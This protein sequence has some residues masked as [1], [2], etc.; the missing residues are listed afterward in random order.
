[1]PALS[2]ERLR[3]S[4]R[5]V[6]AP[7]AHPGRALTAIIGTLLVLGLSVAQVLIGGT[8]LL[9]SLPAYG[10]IGLTA[11]LALFAVRRVRTE[12]SHLCLL[13]TVL[14]LGYVLIRAF[15]SPVDY[16]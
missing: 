3:S 5:L 9:F 15:L 8:R 1:M 7:S 10:L 2:S 11:L 16:L 13:P 6:T 4:N 12:P 14:F